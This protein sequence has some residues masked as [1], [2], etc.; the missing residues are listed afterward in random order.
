MFFKK[1]LP[2][3]SITYK[4]LPLVSAWWKPSFK[5]LR[6]NTIFLYFCNLLVLIGELDYETTNKYTLM[7]EAIDSHN[8]T[9]IRPFYISVENV[10]EAPYLL[11]FQDLSEVDE[12]SSDD[13]LI[14]ALSVSFFALFVSVPSELP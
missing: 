2:L 12:G 8:E 7:V 14:A 1:K 13:T 5:R 6:L 10:N 4:T 11:Q 9:T 3:T